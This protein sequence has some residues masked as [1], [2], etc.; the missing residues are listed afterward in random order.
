MKPALLDLMSCPKCKGSFVLREAQTRDTEIE[1]GR[2]ECESCRA[3][4]GIVDFI[5]RFVPRENYADNFTMQWRRFRR[6]QLDSHSGVPISARRFFDQSGW[7]R[8]DLE[9]AL[10]LDVGCGAGRFVEVALGCGAEVV[11]L[12]YS[13]AV[14]A[15]WENHAPHPRLHVVQGDIYA[16]PFREATFDYVYCF[17]VLQHTPDP[18][19][20]FSCLPRALRSDGRLAI[21]VYPKTGLE[22]L[23]PKYWL[24]PLSKR[25]DSGHLFRVLEAVTPALLRVSRVIG[26]TPAVGHKLRYLVPVANYH[27]VYELDSQQLLDWAVLDTFDMFGPAYDQPQ[28][29][30]AVRGW[31]E[32]A[33][34]ADVEV[35]RLGHLVGRA[36]KP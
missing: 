28:S 1:R 27:G 9:G 30:A 17:G 34:L 21:D 33:R 13:G 8:S 16:L 22:W 15:C 26:S 35:L 11:A 14:D 18:A 29:E 6:T 23:W 25:V 3:G 24:R 2:L 5:P 32:R 20:A 19:G 7:D 12:D 31:F 10:V 4:Y 36:R